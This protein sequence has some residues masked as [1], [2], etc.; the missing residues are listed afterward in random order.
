[1]DMVMERAAK[2]AAEADEV[3]SDETLQ[4]EGMRLAAAYLNNEET[5]LLELLKSRAPEEQMA[6]RGGMAR[7]LLRNIVLPRDQEI[8]NQSLLSRSAATPPMSAPSAP[9]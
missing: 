3:S 6:V 5:D 1:M 7:T 9:N 4:N 8:S 2:L